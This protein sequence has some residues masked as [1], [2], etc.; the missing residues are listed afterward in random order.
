[1]GFKIRFILAVVIIARGSRR[2]FYA[3]LDL[4]KTFLAFMRTVIGHLR[5]FKRAFIVL[6]ITYVENS[7]RLSL[8]LPIGVLDL[9][10]VID[11]FIWRVVEVTEFED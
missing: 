6:A 1:M 9:N 4:F 2:H 3:E 7:E 5:V 10:S 11:T 8:F